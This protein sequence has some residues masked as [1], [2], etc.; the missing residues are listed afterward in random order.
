MIGLKLLGY[1][2]QNKKL[3]PVEP[4]NLRPFDCF[5]LRA[6]GRKG[7]SK[8]RQVANPFI[9]SARNEQSKEGQVANPFILSARNEQ[10]KEG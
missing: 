10:S 9:L 8:E 3:Q 1:Q 5:A 4:S 6:S 7:K 2:N